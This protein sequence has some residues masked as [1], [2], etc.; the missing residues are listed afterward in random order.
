MHSNR[1]LHGKEWLYIIL[2]H[3]FEFIN[4]LDLYIFKAF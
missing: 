2:R 4:S 1:Y 3:S